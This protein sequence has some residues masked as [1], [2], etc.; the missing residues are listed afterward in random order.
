MIIPCIVW[1]LSRSVFYCFP[2]FYLPTFICGTAGGGGFV[3]IS[4]FWCRALKYAVGQQDSWFRWIMYRHHLSQVAFRP[5]VWWESHCSEL[6]V[7]TLSSVDLLLWHFVFKE[8]VDKV[9]VVYFSS[10]L[11]NGC[12]CCC[13]F[14]LQ[15]L[16]SLTSCVVGERWK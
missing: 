16:F 7:E 15:A 1:Q 14:L 6:I 4:V 3:F 10:L 12:V 2:W 9:L 8:P 11:I 13:F 5:P